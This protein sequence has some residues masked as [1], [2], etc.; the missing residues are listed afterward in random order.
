VEAISEQV[1]PSD[2]Y[3]GG[4]EAGVAIFIDL[5]LAGPYR[6]FGKIYKEDLAKVNET[7]LW[8]YQ[9]PFVDCPS[10]CRQTSWPSWRRTQF[11]ALCTKGVPKVK[12]KKVW[13][14]RI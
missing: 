1:I 13:I 8:L 7:T 6:R 9:K 3:S 11:P 14:V 10:I 4:K 2:Q 5:Q 12:T